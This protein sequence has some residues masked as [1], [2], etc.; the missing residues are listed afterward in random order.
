MIDI[1]IGLVIV[2]V[3]VSIALLRGIDGMVMVHME[4]VKSKT[5]KATTAAKTTTTTL[6]QSKLFATSEDITKVPSSKETYVN[7]S[8]ENNPDKTKTFV[9]E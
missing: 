3:V 8:T 6:S 2:G 5:A 9:L 7:V 1:V 4:M